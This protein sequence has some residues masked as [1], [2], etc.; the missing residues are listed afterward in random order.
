MVN[1]VWK[2]QS[3]HINNINNKIQYIYIYIIEY[4]YIYIYIA[5][6]QITQ[7]ICESYS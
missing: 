5:T 7:H 2:R 3:K 1:L 4:R 6:L